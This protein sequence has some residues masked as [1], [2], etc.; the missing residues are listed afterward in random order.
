MFTSICTV[1]KTV[2]VYTSEGIL[3]PPDGILNKTEIKYISG[4]HVVIY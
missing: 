2:S 1:R 3:A 4:A